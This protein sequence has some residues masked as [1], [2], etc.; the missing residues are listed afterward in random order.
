MGRRSFL[1]LIVLLAGGFVGV[2]LATYQPGIGNQLLLGAL[3]GALGAI[4]GGWL[5]AY[6]LR[7]ADDAR[8]GRSDQAES[9]KTA[10]DVAAALRALRDES[11]GNSTDIERHMTDGIEA[12][13]GL[14]DENSGPT[15]KSS[16]DTFPPT[17]ITS[18]LDAIDSWRL[19][20][21]LTKSKLSP[22]T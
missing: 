15:R 2:A 19:P 6:V 21:A 4:A 20:D 18:L 9:L 11:A 12:T 16:C 1:Y 3:I 14:R 17:S 8:E 7:R 13:T 22:R 5:G 10:R